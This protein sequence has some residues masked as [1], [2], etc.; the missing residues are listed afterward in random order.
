MGEAWGKCSRGCGGGEQER[1]RGVNNEPAYGG[2]ICPHA[3]ETRTCNEHHCPIHCEASEPQAW[4]ACSRTC[5]TGIMLKKRTIT[6][7][8][9]FGGKGC[10]E[11]VTEASCNTKPCA[12]DCE[13]GPWGPWDKCSKPCEMGFQTHHRKVMRKAQHGGKAFTKTS[14][15]RF[16]N[17]FKCPTNCTV[18]KWASWTKCG[19]T[20]GGDVKQRTRQ[21]TTHPANGGDACPTLREEQSCNS[22][23]CPIDC[24]PT[25]WGSYSECYTDKGC[26]KG[27]RTRQR[28]VDIE[29]QHGGSNDACKVLTDSIACDAG[30][31]AVDCAVNDWVRGATA[32]ARAALARTRARARSFRSAP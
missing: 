26:G 8:A 9:M 19:K 27:T 32:R 14:E 5:G 30:P 15:A 17:T 13:M 12:V 11:L 25:Y 24:V 1:V 22:G 4:G 29:A 28:F 21:I 10:G 16:C 31:C 3:R 7:H 23:P 2:T 6:R 20:C 18:G